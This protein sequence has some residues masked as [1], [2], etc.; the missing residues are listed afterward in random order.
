MRPSSLAAIR[1]VHLRYYI[2]KH[3]IFSN[4]CATLCCSNCHGQPV[5][6]TEMDRVKAQGYFQ[7]GHFPS[8]GFIPS[9]RNMS[10]L[11]KEWLSFSIQKETA[12][13]DGISHHLALLEAHARSLYRNLSTP[14]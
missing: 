5:A 12:L 7:R 13:K 10:Y 8:A 9:L 11:R 4:H 2:E 1:R 14:Y 3:A 6:P